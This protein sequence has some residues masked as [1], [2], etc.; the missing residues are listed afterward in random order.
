MNKNELWNRVDDSL[1][2]VRPY[3]EK[4]G[5]NVEIVEIT[6]SK[7]V[8]LRL[9]G[10]CETC[11]QSLMTLKSGIEESIKRDVPEIKAI[12]TVSR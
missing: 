7:V 12:E 5:G 1:N 6:D 9:L 4:D 3:L 10:A 8:K 2:S 11:P